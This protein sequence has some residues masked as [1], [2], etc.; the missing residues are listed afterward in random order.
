MYCT[1]CGTRTSDLAN[2]CPACGSRI[3]QASPTTAQPAPVAPPAPPAEKVLWVFQT[4]RKFSMMNIVH[5]NIV[6]TSD[7]VVLAYVTQALRKSES[8]RVSEQIKQEGKGFLKGSA[9]MMKFWSDHYKKYYTL[10]IP[11]ILA[12]DP[13]NIMIENRTITKAFFKGFN[14]SLTDDSGSQISHGKLQLTL[15][16]GETIKFTHSQSAHKSIQELLYGL[17]GERLKYR[18]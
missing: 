1:N 11:E 16:N 4:Q 2:F 5:C 17:F 14:E 12:E 13:I 6:F 15:A 3:N 9:Q 7:K 8:A 10:S 18:K